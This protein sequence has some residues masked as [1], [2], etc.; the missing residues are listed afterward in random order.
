LRQANILEDGPG[1]SV[2]EDSEKTE[3]HQVRNE[4]RRVSIQST[5]GSGAAGIPKYHSG[6]GRPTALGKNLLESTIG[7]LMATATPDFSLPAAFP[8]RACDS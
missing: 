6:A 3:T 5:S 2:S 8:S 7:I 4:N 1:G